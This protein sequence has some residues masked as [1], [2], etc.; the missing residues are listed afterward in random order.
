[1]KRL[2][3]ILLCFFILVDVF[4][5]IAFFKQDI[6]SALFKRTVSVTSEV[7]SFTASISNKKYLDK[8][9]EESDLWNE[10]LEKKYRVEHLQI[11]LTDVPQAM[12][13]VMASAGSPATLT[14]YSYQYNGAGK[15]LKLTV[16]ANLK[17][18]N[19][20]SPNF[21]YSYSA[22]FAIFNITS[23]SSTYSDNER[24]MLLTKY[25]QDFFQNSP[26]SNFFKVVHK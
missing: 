7:P 26:N 1:M 9:L 23:S 18:Q 25:M 11:I 14:S 4:L 3:V 15:N 5:A 16:Q 2:L 19:S 13:V 20:D 10:L 6:F 22:L 21:L 12:G 24:D 17:A 8:K